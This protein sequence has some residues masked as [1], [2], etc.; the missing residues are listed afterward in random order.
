MEWIA[1]IGLEIHVQL[2]T[3]SGIFCGSRNHFGD[4]PNTNISYLNTGQPGTLPVLNEEA[5]KKAVQFGLATGGQIAPFCKFDR[6]S[7]FYPDLPKGFQ[8]TQYDLPIIRGGS[9]TTRVDGKEMT[10]EISHA[11]LEEDTGTLKHFSNFTGI[12]YNRAGAPLIEIVSKPC[13]HTP[14][15]AAQYAIQIKQIMHYINASNCN[16][17]EGSLRVDCNVSVKRKDEQTLRPKVEI[18]NINSFNYIKRAIQLEIDR[19]IELYENNPN[20]DF[21]QLVPSSTYRFDVVANQNVLMRKKE[22]HADYRFFPEPDLVPIVLSPIYIEEIKETL[23]ELPYERTKRYLDAYCLS[24]ETVELLI[25]K[26][27]LSDYFEQALLA[28]EKNPTAIANWIT[29]EFAGRLKMSGKTILD[30]QIV[31]EYLAQLVEMIDA[32]TITGKIAKQVADEMLSTPEKT[33]RQI[34]EN[35]PAFKPLDDIHVLLPIVDQVIQNN[36]QS[37]EDFKNGKDRA[38]GFLIGQIMKMTKGQADPK[39]VNELLRKKLT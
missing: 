26:K 14:Q 24:E 29:V 27:E 37:I 31:P 9:I 23:P 3:Q 34:V 8:I 35:N 33:P 2:N 4:E 20:A 15:E 7:Y 22:T 6:K 39:V 25:S 30:T 17:E 1:V 16:M 10:F 21:E 19:Q 18:K 5:I 36:P 28:Y 13:M 32:N 12:D 38:F 11:H